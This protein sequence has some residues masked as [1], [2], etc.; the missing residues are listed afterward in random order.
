MQVYFYKSK[1]YLNNIKSLFN[2]AFVNDYANHIH[3]PTPIF[4]KCKKSLGQHKML[5][6][7]YPL[8]KSSTFSSAQHVNWNPP[9]AS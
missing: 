5:S 3:K 1:Q 9:K 2:D 4:I 6:L 8:S 7:L